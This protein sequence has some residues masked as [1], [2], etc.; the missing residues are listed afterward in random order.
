MKPLP[1]TW[2]YALIFWA[3]FVWAFWP[4]VGIINRARRDV[5][6]AAD[7]GSLRVILL[8][9]W[10]AFLAAFPL[11][12]VPAAQLPTGYRMLAFA[13]GV[14][15]LVAGSLLR[16]HCWRVLGE[17]FTGNVQARPDQ[18]IMQSGAYALVRHPSY[19]GGIL[20]NTGIGLALGSWASAGL[21]AIVSVAV[22][23]YR[24]QVEERT[25]LAT[26]GEPYRRFLQGR[27]RLIPFVY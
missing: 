11:A 13:V 16:R 23:R 10:V 18:P 14:A 17:S 20:M 21:L 27:K 12:S 9:M 15:V 24:M 3:V 4:E 26:I 25:L 19:T 2:P 1:Y 6:S 8:G 22:Y 7:G 5:D